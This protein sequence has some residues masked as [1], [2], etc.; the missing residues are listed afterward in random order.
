M[1]KKAQELKLAFEMMEVRREEFTK[2]INETNKKFD[3]LINE[4]RKLCDHSETK[5]VADASG[6]NDSYYVCLICGL[7]KKRFNYV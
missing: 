6:N 7:E 4:A 1:T 3:T 5:Y 2:L